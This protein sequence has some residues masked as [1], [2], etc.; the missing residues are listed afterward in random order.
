MK[1]KKV[2]IFG[3]LDTLAGRLVAMVHQET[4][5]EICLAISVDPLPAL[6]VEQEHSLRPHN[7]TDF[8]IN[9]SVFGVPIYVGTEYLSVLRKNNVDSCFIAESSATRRASIYAKLVA[10][11]ID[12]LSFIH[13]STLLGGQNRIGSGTV[14]FPGCNLGFKTDIERCTII[15]SG[16]LIE[17][18]SVVGNY[19][20]IFPRVTTGGFVKINDFARINI[21]VDISNRVSIGQNSE[22]GA[23]SLVLRSCE[24]NCVYYG[25]PARLIRPVSET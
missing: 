23:G 4:D 6:D 17:H 11:G 18:H 5:F 20:N 7:R 22:I 2:A 13:S 8:P 3:V 21:S 19:V 9:N 14:I 24:A 15:Q 1:S 10:N 25:R 12:V 16:G